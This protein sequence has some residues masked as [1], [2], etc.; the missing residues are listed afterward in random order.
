MFLA[1]GKVRQAVVLVVLEN[2][3]LHRGLSFLALSYGWP[4]DLIANQAA[5]ER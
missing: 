5:R 4:L 3:L 2:E 1:V